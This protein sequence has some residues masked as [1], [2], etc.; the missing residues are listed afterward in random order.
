MAKECIPVRE[1]T[2][3][4]ND[5]PWMNNGIRREIRKRNRLHTKYI[6]KRTLSNFTEFKNQRNKVNNMKKYARFF[7]PSSMA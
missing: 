3:R 7:Y 2:I 6:T 4:I 5:K 1:V